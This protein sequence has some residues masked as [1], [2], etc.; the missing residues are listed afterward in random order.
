MGGPM[1][2][3]AVQ[4]TSRLLLDPD[5]ASGTFVTLIVTALAP[6]PPWPS[7]TVAVTESVA[8]VSA[9]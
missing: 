3:G 4:L 1:F 8:L 5:G 6:L 7:E 2:S 9:S